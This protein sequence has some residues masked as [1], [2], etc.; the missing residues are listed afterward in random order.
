MSPDDDVHTLAGP[1]ALDAI[2]D[3]T[4]LSRFERHLD[5]CT[6]CREE[7]R[8]L[9]ETVA[10]LAGS[11]VQPPPP[12]LRSRVL[13]EIARTEQ[14]PASAGPPAR[15]AAPSPATTPVDGPVR[16]RGDRRRSVPRPRRGHRWALAASVVALAGGIMAGIGGIQLYRAEQA[17]EETQRILAIASDPAAQLV[18]APLTGGGSASV[19]IAGA[20]A[21]VVTSDVPAL[22]DDRI[23]QLWLVRRNQI[24]SAGIGPG[25][26][27][28]AGRW[29][30]IIDGVRA[31]DMVAISVEPTGGSEQ[32][33]TT[34]LTTLAV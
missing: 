13:E 10:V 3:D 1:Y 19:V 29:S 11:A 2:A 15:P 24:V 5:D 12:S 9:R 28:A 8:E 32:P 27:D 25:G 33:T 21:A 18:T 30:R 26:G 7:V 22:A 14:L 17:R 20:R 23:Y 31:G 4:E 34:P 6:A 16:H